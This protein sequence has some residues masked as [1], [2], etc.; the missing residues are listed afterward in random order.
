MAIPFIR[1]LPDGKR[2]A[3]LIERSHTVENKA[4][5]FLDRG[6][7]YL[8][9]IQTDAKVHLMAILGFD[10][11]VEEVAALSCENGPDLPIAVDELV[12]QSIANSPPPVE[13][14]IIQLRKPELTL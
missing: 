3:Q 1:K 8:I 2:V 12:E 11:K 9:E 7:R 4:M 14:K 5:A 13:A 10:D 6:G